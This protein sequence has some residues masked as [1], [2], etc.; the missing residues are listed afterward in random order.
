M[1]LE[2]RRASLDD[3]LR[4]LFEQYG[5]QV[6]AMALALG[7]NQGTGLRTHPVAPTHAM[8]VVHANQDAA[9]KWLLERRDLAERRE[10]IGMIMN[11]AVLVFIAWTI[12]LGIINLFRGVHWAAAATPSKGVSV[13]LRGWT[14]L[15]RHSRCTLSQ[16]CEWHPPAPS[17]RAP[18]PVRRAADQACEVRL[19][20]QSAHEHRALGGPRQCSCRERLRRVPAMDNSR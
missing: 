11:A 15:C 6:V 1:R 5:E 7:S 2:V 4:D 3:D 13:Q 17:A 9:A 18:T 14:N 16:A 8:S 19:L 20:T 10:T 12:L